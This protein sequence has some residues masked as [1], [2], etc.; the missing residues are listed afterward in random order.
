MHEQEGSVRTQTEE[1]ILQNME[2]FRPLK[3]N[4]GMFSECAGM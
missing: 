3:K 1:A 4:I 2:K